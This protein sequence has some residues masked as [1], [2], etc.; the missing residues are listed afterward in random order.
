[1]PHLVAN[2]ILI[3]EMDRMLREGREVHF[4][5]SGVSMRPFIEGG[6][7]SVTL[8]RPQEVKV[9]DILLCRVAPDRFV[10]HRLIAIDGDTL[11][12]MG[13]GNLM[14]TEGCSK[15]DVIG[16]VISITRPNGRSHKP[17][18]GRW[19]YRLLPVRKWLLKA[20]RKKLKWLGGIKN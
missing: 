15:A 4:T 10:L 2:A 5:P 19:W 12:L 11:M 13:D 6:R 20:Y 16:R 17:G 3:P 7:D 1:M 14:G 9:G 8:E 18:R